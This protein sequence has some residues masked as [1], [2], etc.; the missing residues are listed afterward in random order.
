MAI[1]KNKAN[2]IKVLK[3]KNN[4]IKELKNM[5]EQKV[6]EKKVIKKKVNKNNVIEKKV[7]KNNVIEKKINKNNV[8][9]KKVIEKKVNKNNVIEKKV[10]KNNVIEKKINKNNVIE[11]KVI[12]KKVNKNNIVEVKNINKNK[13]N[14]IKEL[15]ELKYIITIPI[16]K[17]NSNN[18]INNIN[19]EINNKNKNLTPVI[20]NTYVAE[21][22]LFNEIGILDP[23]GLHNN[24]F[25]DM[26]YSDNYK[27]L[28]KKWSNF[29]MYSKREES[30]K[31]IYN[32]QVLLVVS[33]TGSGKTVLTPKF[34]LHAL[35]YEGRIAITNPKRAP[36]KENA[37]FA[38]LCMDVE[39]GTY[40][41]MKYRNSD[42]SS[43]SSD[44]RLIYVTDGWI[45]QKLQNDPLLSDIDVVIIDEAHE[46]GIQIDLLLLLLKKLLLVRPEFKLIIMSATINSKLFIDYFPI[47]KFKFAMIDAG[48]VPNYPIKEFFL[49]KPINTFD[50]NGC[51]MGNSYIE[52]AVDKALYLLRS[53]EIGDILVFLPGKSDTNKGCMLLHQKLEKLNK[54]LDK[55]LYCSSLTASTDSETQK[56]ITNGSKYKES[57]KYTRKVI[58]AT[59]VAESSMTF[60]G[61]DFVIDTGLVHDSLYYSEKNMSALERKYIS[62]ASHK[63]RKG[64]TG[65]LGPGNCYNLFTEK[66]YETSFKEFTPAPILTEDI[67]TVLLGF[68]ANNK[69]ISHINFPISYDNT[70]NNKSANKGKNVKK[71]VN[72]LVNA[73]VNKKVN[74]MINTTETTLNKI[75]LTNG[76]ELTEFLSSF[77]QAPPVENVKCII[78]RLIALGAVSVENNVGTITNL[79]IAMSM[80]NVLPEIGK[81]LISSYNYHCRDDI[82]NLAAIFEASDYRIENVFEKFK[83]M[84][85]DEAG[86]KAEKKN[87]EKAKNKFANSL[88]DAISLIDIYNEFHSYKYDTV[89]RKTGA[90]IR[91]KKGD[92]R[93]WCRKNFVRYSSMEKIKNASKQIQFSFG[94]VISF[95]H[96]L[97]KNQALSTPPQS[98]SYIFLDK[99]PILGNRNENI[100]HSILDGF[101]I[102]L[103][104]KV[105]NKYI[106]CFPIKKTKANLSMDSLYAQSKSQS[107]Y[108]LYTQLRSILGKTNYAVISKLSP[109]LIKEIEEDPFKNKCVMACWSTMPEELDK[110]MDKSFKKGA[111]RDKFRKSMD[112]F[113]KKDTSR[114]KFDKF[115]KFTD[116]FRKR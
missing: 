70:T 79:G 99:P 43:Y 11:K 91:E 106:N 57:G 56:L 34:A 14:K 37:I 115:K 59:E 104:K 9:E 55:K 100:I 31:A 110:N 3:S 61:V 50:S 23:L 47:D 35:N 54:T 74:I 16:K 25:T 51:L 68:L 72:T 76:V 20:R 5:N 73:K 48:E 24:P 98:S 58:F 116:K 26:T 108:A 87:Y 111:S 46:R 10:N 82:I 105:G 67:S 63:Q 12:K 18:N 93:E 92:A 53:N 71:M 7:N 49:D 45:L 36:T 81:M 86:K 109:A 66:E 15:K 85:K 30:I 42:P 52:V 28:A 80:F 90:I 4:K 32:N 69:L 102:N 112:R 89:D 94:K 38:A 21:R 6:I 19:N 33:G 1:K 65:R 75:N 88:G 27:E 107:K 22:D 101:Y 77:I 13:L 95:Y 2:N 83:P 17:S 60:P 41:G 29:P 97:N 64:R 40:I 103:M 114:Y 44:N 84:S 78:D 39:L 8:I 113:K 96:R 62:K